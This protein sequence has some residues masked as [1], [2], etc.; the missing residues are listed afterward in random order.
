MLAT[1]GRVWMPANNRVHSSAALQT[2]G[3]LTFQC[4]NFL[5]AKEEAEAA[6][7]AALER[8]RGGAKG[9][10]LAGTRVAT[11]ATNSEKE[12]EISDND[13]DSEMERALARLGRSKKESSKEKAPAKRG[14]K[15]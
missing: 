9:K 14:L 7:V 15:R 11:D 3:R 5:T 12:T 4:R 13:E 1:A 2:R 10:D 8:E 6:A